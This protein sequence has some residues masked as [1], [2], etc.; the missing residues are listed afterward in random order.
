MSRQLMV[1][2]GLGLLMVSAV[3]GQSNSIEE[4]NEGL[5]DTTVLDGKVTKLDELAPVIFLNRTKAY[6]NCAA[7]YMQIE[8]KFEEPFYGIAYADFDRSSACQVAG[9]GN[10]TARIDLPL[11]GC[12]T[13]QDPTRVFTNNIVVRFHPALEMDGDEVITIVCRYPPPVAPPP[14][15]IPNFIKEEPAPALPVG[16]PL[17]A[18]QILLVICGILF[19]S[20]VLLG[21]GCS[22]YLLKRRRVQVVRRH[23]LSMGTGSEIT[24]LSGSSLGNIS[25]FEG[26]KIPRAHAAMASGSSTGSEAALISGG[27]TLPS[28][29]PSESPSSAHSEVE[30]IDTRSLHRSVSSGGSFDNKAYVRE[31]SYFAEGYGAHSE[32]E[33]I[34]SAAARLPPPEPQFDVQVR[35]K[36]APPPPPSPTPPPSESEASMRMQE[37]N[38]T[39]ILEGEEFSRSVSAS[40]APVKTTFT[41]VPELHAPPPPAPPPV[42]SSVIRKHIDQKPIITKEEKW[43]TEDSVDVIEHR[44]PIDTEMIDTRSTTEV[45]ERF[46]K[47]PA[48]PPPVVPPSQMYITREELHTS[49]DL[50]EPPVVVSRRPEITSHVVDDVFLRTIT[51]KKTIEDIE[52][53]RRQVTEYH[54]KPLPK[55][56][57]TI[58]NYPNPDAQIP[59]SGTI[60]DWDSYSETS[61]ISGVPQIP[62]HDQTRM[63]HHRMSTDVQRQYRSTLEIPVPNPPVPNWD[64]LIRVL[65]PPV[66]ETTTQEIHRTE[67]DLTLEDRRKWREIITTES[68]LRTLLTEATVKEDYERIR[69]DVR[70]EKLFEPQ[71]W[72]VIIRVLA[73]PERPAYDQRGVAGSNRYRRKADWDTRSRRS[74]LPTL[75]EYDSDGG[76]SVRTLTADNGGPP[77]VAS[78][79]S[80]RTSRSSLRSDMDVRS[81]SEMTV[82]FARP[83][84]MSD[85]SSYYRPRRFYD[86]DDLPGG[87]EDEDAHSLVRSVSQPSLARSASEFTEHW[88][89]RRPQWDL[90]SPEHSPRS[91]RSH[92]MNPAAASQ[93]SSYSVRQT[94]YQQSQ[95]WFADADS[96]ASYK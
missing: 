13:R 94:T 86:D 26:L 18:F 35:V 89:I 88:G 31:S 85:A 11:K 44:R 63:E 1:L 37:R 23:P 21:L 68:T 24:K 30:D 27:D 54:P 10:K 22:Y 33:I 8:L 15:G 47:R 62:E 75:Y 28:D 95:N 17:K 64:V 40:P 2:I 29:Y 80:R 90:S 59:D 96:E 79:R 16:P 50:I 45:F 7:G 46:Q 6:L 74:S 61:S 73:P 91:A 3:S 58:R 77:G 32:T 83:D 87:Y 42:Y 55:W 41:Y 52:R 60:T 34:Q 69:K 93:S 82:D 72:D 9:R 76:S 78:T 51:E 36:R 48:P 39:T 65:E 38:L 81:M 56:D 92:R 53:H 66:Q 25:M 57:V 12:G 84:N 67:M 5:P 20:L 4:P 14:A 71:K 49:E 19:L 43:I 70:Y